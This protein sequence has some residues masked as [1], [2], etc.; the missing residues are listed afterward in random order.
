MVKA[1]LHIEYR[2]LRKLWR[3]DNNYTSNTHY[4]LLSYILL[5]FQSQSVFILYI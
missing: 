3:L 1:K 4:S 2:V 5:K